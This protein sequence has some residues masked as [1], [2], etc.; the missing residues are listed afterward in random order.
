MSCKKEEILSQFRGI[1]RDEIKN[2]LMDELKQEILSEMPKKQRYSQDFKKGFIE[3]K[4][5]L[6]KFQT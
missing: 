6:I 1:I 4:N 2:K 3:S 5:K